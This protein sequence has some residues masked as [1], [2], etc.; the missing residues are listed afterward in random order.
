MYT[1]NLLMDY[2]EV[3]DLDMFLTGKGARGPW[4]DEDGQ[5]IFTEASSPT[6]WVVT[7]IWGFQMVEVNGKVER[8]LARNIV[9]QREKDGKRADVRLVYDW[10]GV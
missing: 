1:K 2:A 5:L 7:Q 8:R 4:L 6:G 3:M 10:G 9:A